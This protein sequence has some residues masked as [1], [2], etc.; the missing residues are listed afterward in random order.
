MSGST[1][2]GWVRRPFTTAPELN[3]I[4]I[5]V[6]SNGSQSGNPKAPPDAVDPVESSKK[7]PPN[8]KI[9]PS[10]PK[11]IPPAWMPTSVRASRSEPNVTP[12]ER[13]P[14]YVGTYSVTVEDLFG[15]TISTIIEF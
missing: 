14:D 15:K 1:A 13:P 6:I 3:S 4:A 5:V 10:A 9:E 12:A 11:P 2:N 7:N 8:M